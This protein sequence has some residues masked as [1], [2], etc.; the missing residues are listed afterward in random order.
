M[1][2]TALTRTQQRQFDQDS[3]QDIIV[4]SVH[5]GYVVTDMTKQTG[6]L[7]VEEGNMIILIN[8][9]SLSW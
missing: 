4:N 1:G 6:T 8:V 9:E 5:P 2:I 3:R 7:S